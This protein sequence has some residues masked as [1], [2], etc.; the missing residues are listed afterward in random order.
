MRN[1]KLLV[2]AC[3]GALGSPQAGQADTSMGDTIS[4]TPTLNNFFISMV[5]TTSSSRATEPLVDGRCYWVEST[6]RWTCKRKGFTCGG[7][8]VCVDQR[9]E[10]Q[11]QVDRQEAADG[12]DG[13]C[14]YNF[15]SN[16]FRCPRKGFECMDEVFCVDKRTEGERMEDEEEEAMAGARRK[17][18]VRDAAIGGTF[19]GILG[20]LVLSCCC[21]GCAH[22]NRKTKS[23]AKKEERRQAKDDRAVE[24]AIV[25]AIQKSEAGSPEQRDSIAL[26]ERMR[27]ARAGGGAG[28][29]APPAGGD[30][31]AR[32]DRDEDAN[33]GGLGHVH[34]HLRGEVNGDGDS[35]GAA[36]PA[37]TA[38][39]G[40]AL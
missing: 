6:R 4:A 31:A 37:Y 29:Q 8:Y 5:T 9:T 12:N 15:E 19:G 33:A 36:L 11:K 40:Q 38:Y 35:N 27:A 1:I 17:K 24:H 30:G 32:R 25:K 39:I 28:T 20:L 26:W 3:L 7:D 2:L 16:T 13:R 10:L 14:L 34:D 21:C 18:R 22:E 23:R